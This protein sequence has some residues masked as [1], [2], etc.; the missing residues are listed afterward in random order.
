MK[1]G[2]SISGGLHTALVVFA[3]WGVDWFTDQ[4]D[5]PLTIT[6]IELVNGTDFEAALSTAPVVPSEGPADLAQPSETQ[7]DPGDVPRPEDATETAEAPKAAQA[8]PP[9][10]KPDAPELLIPPPPTNVPTEAPVATIAEIPSP[11][12]LDRKSLEPESPA[13]TEP[14]QPLRSVNAPLPEAKPSRPPDPEPEPELAEP[15]PK[16]ETVELAQ[17][18]P[19]PE[20]A[21]DRPAVEERPQLSETQ[22]DQP[23]A[24][25]TAEAPKPPP[26]PEPEEQTEEV[27][28][29]QPQAPEGPA[30]KVAKLPLAK[31]A[32][33]AAAAEAARLAEQRAKEEAEAKERERIAAAN[34]KPEQQTRPTQQ[35]GGSDRVQ[36]RP[37]SNGERNALR[38]GIKK[39]YTYSGDRS[40]RDLRVVIRVKLN[41]DGSLIGNPEQRSAQ[42]GNANSQRALF[43]AGR[44]AIIRAAADGAFKVLP[45]D[46]YG[47][48][49][50]LNFRFSID[51]VGKVS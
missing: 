16:R 7:G 19:D 28:L 20:Q 31:P 33:L 25:D 8:P 6:E 51:G 48:W 32:D 9:D 46:K 27:E 23:S 2:A 26:Q 3:I 12:P 30:P 15:D 14:V 21:T 38:V 29:S 17:A 37:L 45:Q 40:D 36:A 11:D 4:D 39:Y 50:V 47:R 13:A 22:P 44:R 34:P 43:Q 41:K 49:K 35:A 1:V 42:G 24:P 5:L 18:T 10:A